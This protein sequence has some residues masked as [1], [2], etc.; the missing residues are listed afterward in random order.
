[1]IV[2]EENTENNIKAKGFVVQRHKTTAKEEE[3]DAFGKEWSGE[4]EEATNL[5]TA[6]RR[7]QK[8]K[9]IKEGK[10]ERAAS[11]CY[12]VNSSGW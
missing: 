4:R 5:H 6:T 8:R 3:E 12:V 10:N 1:M 7:R 11:D 2:A 9:K